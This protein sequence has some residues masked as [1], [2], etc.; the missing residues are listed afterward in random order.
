[1]PFMQLDN[2]WIFGFCF[3]YN[4]SLVSWKNNKSNYLSQSMI[5]ILLSYLTILQI[6]T[7]SYHYALHHLPPIFQGT[8]YPSPFSSP[9]IVWPYSVKSIPL[10]E[11][12]FPDVILST[13][14]SLIPNN[15]HSNIFAENSDNIY[16]GT[17]LPLIL[18][19]QL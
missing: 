1:M 10:H 9:L 12:T 2:N 16:Q 4:N 8:F 7:L 19:I 14:H 18:S 15:F 6:L 13:V 17:H 5:I 3:L 11:N